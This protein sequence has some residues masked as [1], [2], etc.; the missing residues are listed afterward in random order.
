M[1]FRRSDMALFGD[2]TVTLQALN[3][4]LNFN[5]TKKDAFV[6]VRHEKKLTVCPSWPGTSRLATKQ[7]FFAVSFCWITSGSVVGISAR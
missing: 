1:D 4:F 5:S 6:I 3:P 2:F 7:I